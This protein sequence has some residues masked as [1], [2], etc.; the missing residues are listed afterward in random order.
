MSITVSDALKIG[1]MSSCK[2]I[3]GRGGLNRKVSYIDT[4]EVPNI[5]PWLKKNLLLITTG[6]SIKD[7]ADAL[8]QLIRNLKKVGAAGLAVKTRFLGDIS[9]TTVELADRLAIPLIEIPKEIPFVEITM[10]LMKAIV[11]EH[12]RNLEFSERMNRK[13][14]ELELDNGGFESIAKALS[15]LIGLPIIIVSRGF[16]VLASSG[17]KAYPVPKAFLEPGPHGD[18]RLSGRI[19]SQIT[20]NKVLLQLAVSEAARLFVRRVMVKKQVYGYICVVSRARSLDDMQLIAL[21]HAATSVA[22]EISKIQKLDEHMRF[23]QNS[24]FLDLLA[25]SVKTENEAQGRAQLLHWP[26]LPIRVAVADIDQFESFSRTVS[27]EKVQNLKTN[28]HS[29]IHDNLLAFNHTV[30]MQSDSFV[31]LLPDSY[32]KENLL[33]TFR[34]IRTLIQTRYHVTVTIGISDV[35]NAYTDLPH[36]YGEACDA[37]TIGRNQDS[38]GPV[39]MISDV[40]LEQA[41]LK[42]CSTPYFSRYV[43]DTIGKLERYDREHQT[44]LTKTLDILLENMGARQKTAEKLFIHRNTLAGRID[45]IEK[46]TGFN[47]AKNEDLFRLGFALKIRFYV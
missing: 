18:L 9:E 32:S 11:D 1:A 6:Y 4:M 45:K 25:G 30:I 5:Q 7:D 47:L 35:C 20:G 43:E 13:F 26:S 39:Q 33:S 36:H 23:L 31:V 41:I 17:E 29:L 14:L 21:N 27:E 3:G 19:C 8:P 22:L 40:R 16:S 15:N 42:S 46:I 37:I 10:P 38:S 12:N 28:I 2:L 44:D 34:T 24:L